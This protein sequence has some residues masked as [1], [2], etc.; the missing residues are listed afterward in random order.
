MAKARWRDLSPRT[1]QVIM[2][3]SAIEGALKVAALI[4]LKRR[5][6]QQIRGSKPTWAAAIILVNSAGVVPLAYFL[7]GRRLP[8]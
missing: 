7:K 1:R 8:S 6:A 5:P 4:D 3:A 2:A